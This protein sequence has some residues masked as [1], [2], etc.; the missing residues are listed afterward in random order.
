MVNHYAIRCF[1]D[2]AIILGIRRRA[3]ETFELDAS[4]DDEAKLRIPVACNDIAIDPALPD[5]APA[6]SYAP[7]PKV[8]AK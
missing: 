5:A 3:G 7:A 8:D 6:K 1:T 2:G 4:A